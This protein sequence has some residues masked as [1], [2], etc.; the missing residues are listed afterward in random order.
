MNRKPV[1]RRL[2]LGVALAAAVLPASAEELGSVNYQFKW[3][4][5]SDRIVVDALDDPEV[6]GV[7]CYIARART[8]GVK[9]ALGLAEDPGEASV[10]CRATGPIDASRIARL[11][12][13][14]NVFSERASLVFKRTRVVRFIDGKRQAL[15]YVVYT[16]RIIN[17]LPQNS[18]T[19]VP[20][21]RS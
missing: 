13:G 3:V 15:V 12:N 4:G 14:E 10:D 16:D 6:P 8:G 7:T 19:V 20:I 2:A 9:G 18:I 5:P 17:G 1:L 11:K 21:N